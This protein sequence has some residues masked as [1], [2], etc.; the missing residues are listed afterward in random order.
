MSAGL[1]DNI[2]RLRRTTGLTQ[3]GLA[4]GADLSLSTIRKVEQG[5][6]VSM[7]TLAALAAALGGL[8]FCPVR[9][10]GP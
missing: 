1:A 6:H 3:E 8:H 10:R 2:K 5:G 4:E 7:D 9:Q